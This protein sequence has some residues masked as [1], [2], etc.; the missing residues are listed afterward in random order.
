MLLK[1]PGRL[2]QAAQFGAGIWADCSDKDKQPSLAVCT[3][4]CGEQLVQTFLAK[5][6]AEDLVVEKNCPTV[7]LHKCLTDKFM[8]SRLDY[9][10]YLISGDDL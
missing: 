9:S 8:N 2:G 6:I 7:D 4:G 5:T 3:T 1:R 10:K